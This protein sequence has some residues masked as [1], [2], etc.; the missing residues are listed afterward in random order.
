M[1]KGFVLLVGAV[2]VVVLAVAVPSLLRARVSAGEA[3]WIGDTRTVIS[4]Q[5]AYAAANGG[6]YDARLQCLNEPSTCIP[7]YT[8]DA[9]VFLDP[10]LASLQT[11]SGYKRFLYPGPP[12][13]RDDI[14]IAK[15][16]PTSVRG[17]AYVAVPV[18]T[19]L[20]AFCGDADGRICFTPNGAM[21]KVEDGR[22]PVPA[23]TIL[24]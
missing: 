11:K 17:F 20:R 14:A 24:Q 3:P 23:C 4:A 9:P 2:V 15:A 5:T 13:S 16:S 19:G 1:S 22:C 7:G 10:A 12:A 8:R 6:F 21:P 18:D